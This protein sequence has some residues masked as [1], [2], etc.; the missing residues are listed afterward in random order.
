M[1]LLQGA[2]VGIQQGAL[3]SRSPVADG[4]LGQAGVSSRALR[5]S[6]LERLQKQFFFQKTT[7]MRISLSRHWVTCPCWH[8]SSRQGKRPV[9]LIGFS[10]GARVIYFCLQEMAKEE[11]VWKDGWAFLC[12][13]SS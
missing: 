4:L 7:K 13:G 12:L 9:S 1:R 10:L 11:G 8:L 6:H 5:T 3:V 2:G